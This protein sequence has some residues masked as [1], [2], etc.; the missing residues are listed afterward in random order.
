MYGNGYLVLSSLQLQHITQW[1]GPLSKISKDR[2]ITSAKSQG[3][4][5]TA[6]VFLLFF[7]SALK[8]IVA[9]SKEIAELSKTFVMINVEV[10]N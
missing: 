2:P 9:N 6:N 8:P 10:L 5:K 3:T 4:G 7:V 1:S